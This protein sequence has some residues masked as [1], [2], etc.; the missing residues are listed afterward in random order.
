MHATLL[1][2]LL[3]QAPTFDVASVRPATPLE[4]EGRN[5]PQIMP[6][7]SG[8][9]IRNSSLRD[10]IQWAWSVREYQVSGP[11]WVTQE[12]YDISAKTGGPTA[13]DQLRAML[14]ELLAER[15]RLRLRE[16]KKEMSV[17]A[18]VPSRGGAKLKPSQHDVEGM[19]RLPG[20]G[21][22]LEF[23]HTT[24]AELAAFLSTLAVVDRPVFDRSGSS[25]VFDFTLDLHEVSGPWASEAERAAGP[26]V[27]TVLQEQIG[28]RFEIRKEPAEVLVVERAERPT[29]N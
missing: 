10:C 29:G 16:D 11:D 18:L 12:K 23:R 17:Y 3:A 5:R 27:S 19:V 6:S 4:G 28:L 13:V 1:L 24:V 22:R 15:F 21:L 2:L 20:G 9:T 26:G 14:R 25:G 8:L 7:P